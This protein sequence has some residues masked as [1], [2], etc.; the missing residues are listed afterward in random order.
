MMKHKLSQKGK[1]QMTMVNANVCK[2][3]KMVDVGVTSAGDGSLGMEQK[4]AC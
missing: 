2:S 1:K 4:Q 3:T